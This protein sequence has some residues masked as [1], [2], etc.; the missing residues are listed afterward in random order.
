MTI[1]SGLVALRE[2]RFN[3]VILLSLYEQDLIFQRDT[4]YRQDFQT[5]YGI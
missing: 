5:L 1:I 3:K 4:R 2:S